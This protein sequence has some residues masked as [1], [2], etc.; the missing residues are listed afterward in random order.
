M[1]LLNAEHISL[2]WGEN[3]LFDDVSFAL[4]E[5]D[6]VGFIGINGTGKST[7]LRILAGMQE[8]DAGT[9][10]LARGARIGYL[11]QS[12][13]F[14]EPITVLQQV[15]RGAATDFAEE[16]AY[17]AKMLLTQLGITDF[18][19]DVRLLSGGQKK[20][21]AICSA[22]INPSEILI[23]DEPTNHIDNE[24]AA[25]LEQQLKAYK[26]A[27][28]IITHDRYFLNRVTNRICELDHAKLYF[29]E[30]N[31]EGFVA[32][33][34]ERIA[35]AAASERKRQTI[36][37]R[38]LEWMRRGAKA[39]TT[40][41][42]GRIQRF[43]ELSSKTV[44]EED[45]Q[46]EMKSISTRL[47]KKTIEVS[48]L[49]KS[50]DGKTYI[51][52][53]DLT[54]ARDDRIGIVGHNGTGKST[55]LRILAG[56]AQP[57]AGTVSYGETVKIG[58]FAQDCGHMDQEQ[59]VIEFI[60]D[61]AETV[62]TPDGTLSA[63]QMLETF[64]FTGEQQWTRIGSLSGGEQRRLYLL[65]VLMSAPNIL[66]LDE[67]TND[68]D[69][70]TLNILENYL[71]GFEG[72]VLAVSHDRYF[73]DKTARR[74]FEFRPNGD[75]QEY[76]GNYADYLDKRKEL[77]RPTAE[78]TEKTEKSKPKNTGKTKMSYK[79]RYELEHIDD[80][81]AELEQKLAALKEEQAQITS[82]FVRLQELSE[83]IETVSGALDA[84][85]ERWI[86]LQEMAELENS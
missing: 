45:G 34:A 50:W 71:E 82:D 74:I 6:K 2:S 79:D 62:R 21:I 47:G 8:P 9:I 48:G 80:E 37:R 55:F 51:R 66:L 38:E 19:K 64:L 59:K 85:E 65:S 68:L 36:L 12:P 22:L 56:Q 7:F 83:Q 57:D 3:T 24:T 35:S 77:E 52:D 23:L 4:E 53:F 54:V 63:A 5:Q 42:K 40:K 10:T 61:I 17:E 18:D 73:L 43:E 76:L 15:F 29:Y 11:P 81:I 69:I 86:E 30:E 14:S 72:A 49:C 41:A 25:W 70:E 16:R 27:L 67:P 46:V 20:R 58:Y 33:K 60:R 84:K 1:V 28:V 44:Q 75:V 31:Y 26:G 13:D 78:K 32:R 39:R